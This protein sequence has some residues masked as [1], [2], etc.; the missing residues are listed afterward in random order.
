MAYMV[1]NAF[2]TSIP[3]T[4]AMAL[5]TVSCKKPPSY[6]VPSSVKGDPTYASKIDNGGAVKSDTPNSTSTSGSA[7]TD[8][9]ILTSLPANFDALGLTLDIR[10]AT[11]KP[12]L[13]A[14]NVEAPL[15]TD[16]AEKNRYVMVPTRAKLDYDAVN[17]NFIFPEGTL[18]VKHFSMKNDKSIPIETRVLLKQKTGWQPAIYRWFPDGSNKRVT[19]VALEEVSSD[20]PVGYRYPAEGECQKCHNLTSDKMLGFSPDQ[21]A[22]S[23]TGLLAKGVLSKELLGKLSG[24]PAQDDPSDLSLPI[25]KRAA[26]YL[27]I[28]CGTCHNPKGTAAFLVLNSENIDLK[29]LESKGVVVPG[30]PAESRLWKRFVAPTQRMPPTTVSVDPVGDELIQRWI[31]SLRK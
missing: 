17:G 5:A 7:V 25:A 26:A 28:N 11:F 30:F 1:R 13:Q 3:L 6:S 8:D 23:L 29:M 16:D 15:W 31:R 10:N 19:T 12:S 14:Y 21:L 4:L 22:S 18:L 24:I 9:A 27:D 2:I 20:F